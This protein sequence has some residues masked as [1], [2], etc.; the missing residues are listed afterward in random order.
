MRLIAC[1]WNHYIIPAMVLDYYRTARWD[2]F[3]HPDNVPTI[4]QGF[5][6]SGGGIRPGRDKISAGAAQ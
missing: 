6:T 2:R 5:Q 1:F 4:F 3:A